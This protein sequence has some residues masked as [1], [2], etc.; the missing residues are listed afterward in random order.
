MAKEISAKCTGVKLRADGRQQIQ[1]E[2]A[3]T[4]PSSPVPG[5]DIAKTVADAELYM[6][7]AADPN[8]PW[9][10]GKDYT[11]TVN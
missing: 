9:A 4:T 11:V 6:S 7:F 2:K 10:V 5:N 8:E 3:A 1:L